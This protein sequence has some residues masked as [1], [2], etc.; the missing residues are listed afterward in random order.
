MRPH[1]YTKEPHPQPA[2]APK[3]APD[4]VVPSPTR[5]AVRGKS[6]LPPSPR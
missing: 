6:A 5:R 2:P 3:W 1:R 4:P